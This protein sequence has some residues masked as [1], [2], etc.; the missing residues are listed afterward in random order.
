MAEQTWAYADAVQQLLEEGTEPGELT[1][2]AVV[3][4]ALDGWLRRKIEI[5]VTLHAAGNGNGHQ[6]EDRCESWYALHDALTAMHA[7]SHRFVHGL[8]DPVK[9]AAS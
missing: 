7:D 3:H 1:Q 9:D 8:L 2:A 4:R 5:A 6:Q